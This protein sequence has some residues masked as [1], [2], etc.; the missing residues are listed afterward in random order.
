MGFKKGRVKIKN[1]KNDFC[2]I[3]HLAWKIKKK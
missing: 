1:I 3:L 2:Q